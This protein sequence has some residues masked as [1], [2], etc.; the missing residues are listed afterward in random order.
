MESTARLKVTFQEQLYNREALD[1]SLD[2][3]RT[4]VC[5][6]GNSRKKQDYGSTDS[7]KVL[8][9]YTEI[10]AR[11]LDQTW[12]RHN[13]LEN[14]ITIRKLDVGASHIWKEFQ[15]NMYIYAGYKW[16]PSWPATDIGQ[17]QRQIGPGKAGG[18]KIL[19]SATAR[20]SRRCIQW[21]LYESHL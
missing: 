8:A 12:H 16:Q 5:D 14:C 10:S 13:G 15:R 19:V 9:R 11:Y 18:S 1:S 17:W 4:L 20:I 3:R 6:R 7:S 21:F 2:Q